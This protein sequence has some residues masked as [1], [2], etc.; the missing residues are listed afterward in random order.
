[1]LVSN[2]MSK[3]VIT[4]RADDSMH[5]AIRLLESNNIRVLPVIYNGKLVGIISDRDLKRASASDASSLEIRELLYL[6]SN[7]KIRHIMTKNPITVPPDWSIEETAQ[8]LIKKKISS[9]PVVD[10]NSKLVGIITQTD[11]F[12]VLTTVS[13]LDKRGI[14]FAFVIEDLPGSI[15]AIADI[16]YNHNGRIV[17]ILAS[18]ENAPTGYRNLYVRAYQI[19]RSQLGQLIEELKEKGK[20]LHMIDHLEETR[21]IF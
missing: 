12:R 7:I 18:G 15:K 20:L 14:Q 10:E 3:P 16:I 19:E 4:V 11:L 9:V 21:K 2:W 1:M 8:I 17:S 5:D 13:G 6:L